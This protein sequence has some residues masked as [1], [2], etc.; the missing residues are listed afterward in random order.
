MVWGMFHSCYTHITLWL[1]ITPGK[2][3]GKSPSMD[4]NGGLHEK[5]HW[6]L[7]TQLWW[8][9]GDGLLLLYPHYTLYIG[10]PT[11]SNRNRG[12]PA[13]GPPHISLEASEGHL[14]QQLQRPAPA[15]AA[16]TQ[17]AGTVGGH[18]GAP[19]PRISKRKRSVGG[20][21]VVVAVGC[22]LEANFHYL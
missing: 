2:S 5:I 3:T 6:K 22:D 12:R 13:P 15:A 10:H 9:L 19:W 1:V 18:W 14:S 16:Q 7:D 20:S 17:G 21:P 11:C 4:I 8:W